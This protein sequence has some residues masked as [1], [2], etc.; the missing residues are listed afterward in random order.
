MRTVIVKDAGRLFDGRKELMLVGVSNQDRASIDGEMRHVETVDVRVNVNKVEHWGQHVTSMGEVVEVEN[1][2]TAR[3][4]GRIII[5][6]IYKVHT[7]DLN[8]DEA[9]L[10]GYENVEALQSAE[11]LGSRYVWLM[12]VQPTSDGETIH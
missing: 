7:D 10:M 3:V 2:K 5:K 12:R 6:Q 9:Q 4:S 11:R 1:T 8:D